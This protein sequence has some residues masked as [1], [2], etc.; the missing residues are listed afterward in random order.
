MIF[1]NFEA[2][3]AFEGRRMKASQQYKYKKKTKLKPVSL[4]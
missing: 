4:N 2:K 1:F 3:I